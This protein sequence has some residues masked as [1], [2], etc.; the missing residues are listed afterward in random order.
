MAAYHAHWNDSFMWKF[1]ELLVFKI[2][3]T[4]HCNLHLGRLPVA[5]VFGFNYDWFG[6]RQQKMAFATCQTLGTGNPIAWELSFNTRRLHS[7]Y[8]VLFYTVIN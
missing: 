3:L 8:N 2:F 1:Q 7:Q 5:R 6:D 4:L